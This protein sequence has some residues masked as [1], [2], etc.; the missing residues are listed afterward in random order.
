MSHKLPT[1]IKRLE[2]SLDKAKARFAEKMADIQANCKHTNVLRVPY[3]SRIY[4]TTPPSAVCTSCGL[5]ENSWNGFLPG[6]REAPTITSLEGYYVTPTLH[7]EM[8]SDLKY[9]VGMRRSS[10]AEVKKKLYEFYLKRL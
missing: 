4:S 6:S 3:E 1:R 8:C 2:A 9:G 10:K 5:S 7:S